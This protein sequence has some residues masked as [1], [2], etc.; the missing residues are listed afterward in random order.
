MHHVLRC[1]FFHPKYLRLRLLVNKR[2]NYL[3]YRVQ[4]D[5][6]V[7]SAL[8]MIVRRLVTIDGWQQLGQDVGHQAAVV[9]Q[10]ESARGV[11][12]AQEFQ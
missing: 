1:M 10:V 3:L 8:R 11:R 2:L 9:K 6:V 4:A 12:G 7:D 5:V